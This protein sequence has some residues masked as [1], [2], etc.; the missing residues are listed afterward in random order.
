MNLISFLENYVEL[1]ER[2]STRDLNERA[3]RDW[4]TDAY[5]LGWE[6]AQRELLEDIKEITYYE[7][8]ACRSEEYGTTKFGYF[9]N[10]H[11][12]EKKLE[13]LKKQYVGKGKDH[14]QDGYF[15]DD[16]SIDEIEIDFED[17][18]EK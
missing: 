10:K 16:W 9:K 2:H 12:A 1:K 5:E 6:Q 15:E 4:L 8:I 3:A 17:G 13:E 11:Y 18:E 14:T 7:I